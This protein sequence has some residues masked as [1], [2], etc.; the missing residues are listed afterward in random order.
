MPHGSLLRL[1]NE[2]LSQIARYL[3]RQDRYSWLLTCRLF[4]DL[5]IDRLYLDDILHDIDGRI[6]GLP[7]S[8]HWGCSTGNVATLE[9][10]RRVGVDEWNC[11]GL[12]LA[13]I[14]GA[15]PT[16]TVPYLLDNGADLDH[17]RS[18][19]WPLVEA[20]L[21]SCHLPGRKWCPVPVL[22]ALLVRGADLSRS[23]GLVMDVWFRIFTLEHVSLSPRRR[24]T[25]STI[26]LTA[27]TDNSAVPSVDRPCV[28]SSPCR[29]ATT[30]LLLFHGASPEANNTSHTLVTMA[31]A[32]L[33]RPAEI[34]QCLADGG[35]D[36]NRRF[37][38]GF[39]KYY[40]DERPRYPGYYEVPTSWGYT[41]HHAI[42][43]PAP[44]HLAAANA[45]L[46]SSLAQRPRGA[47]WDTVS[48]MSLYFSVWRVTKVV[49][50]VRCFGLCKGR[51]GWILYRKHTRD[52]RRPGLPQIL[53]HTHELLETHANY[54][55]QCML[56]PHI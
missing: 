42:E 21:D 13:A 38:P 50:M 35:A 43:S 55:S 29:V 47:D 52:V 24:S 10:A 40:Y 3:P 39:Q 6:D 28:H 49:S 1:P 48:A 45:V 22:Q 32:K 41:R 4:R 37:S 15:D 20:V 25:I 26:A 54:L 53:I 8:L 56:P 34:I 14:G 18:N 33:N 36:L 27:T 16:R 19:T 51:A 11:S 31:M 7:R 2:L 5:V 30:K 17:W 12:I 46:K 9:R 23:H 44:I